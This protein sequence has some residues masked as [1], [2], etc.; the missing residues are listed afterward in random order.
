VVGY[1]LG[2]SVLQTAYVLCAISATVVI[3]GFVAAPVITRFGPRPTM[4]AAAVV[5]AVNFFAL[6]LGHDQ[7]WEYVVSNFAWGAGFAFAYS[8]AAAAYLQDAAPAEAAMYSSANAVIVAGVGGLGAGIFTAVLTSA[9]TIPHTLIPQAGVFTHMW[10][11]AGIAGV[12][13]LALTTIVRRP[14]FVP[15]SRPADPAGT[16]APVKA[17]FQD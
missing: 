13:M 2:Q 14:R 9:S 12:V 8:A 10:V 7:V 6:A 3:G 11:Y 5:I 17:D 1:G 4:A 15:A 16:V